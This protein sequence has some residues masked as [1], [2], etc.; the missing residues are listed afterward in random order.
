MIITEWGGEKK[1]TLKDV[2][3]LGKERKLMLF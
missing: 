3:P 1:E 2:N